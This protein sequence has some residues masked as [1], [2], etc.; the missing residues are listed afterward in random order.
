MTH[1]QSMFET[2]TK[3]GLKK[4]LRLK[5][6]GSVAAI[7]PGNPHHLVQILLRCFQRFFFKDFVQRLFSKD[8]VQRFV[9]N[10]ISKDFAQ[11][12]FETFLRREN[13]NY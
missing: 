8:S 3:P 2:K 4:L 7:G 12:Y 10:N 11:A 9:S 5:D 6:F 1:S 13:H